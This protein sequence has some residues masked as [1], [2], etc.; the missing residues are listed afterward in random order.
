MQPGDV[1]ITFADIGPL[2]EVTGFK[3]AVGVVDGVQWFVDWYLGYT[4]L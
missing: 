2:G 3:P 1:K 4:G